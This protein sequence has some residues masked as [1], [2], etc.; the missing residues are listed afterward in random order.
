MTLPIIYCSLDFV[1]AQ[2]R[3]CQQ[4]DH[5]DT[6]AATIIPSIVRDE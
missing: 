6:K 2:T 1:Q 4:F 5:G 3:A